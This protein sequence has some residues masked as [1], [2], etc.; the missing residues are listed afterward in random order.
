MKFHT[1]NAPSASFLYCLND[2][3]P[4][5]ATCLR[6]LAAHEVPAEVQSMKVV[7]PAA[8]PADTM[9]CPFFKEHSTLR[10]AWGF[11]TLLESL[12]VSAARQLAESL[13]ERW[14]RTAYY[15]LRKGE[16]ALTP[17]EQQDVADALREMGIDK[18]PVFDRYTE[19][20]DWG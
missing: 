20:T 16:Q 3:C 18:E 4:R 12:P 6:C 8:I 14:N 10:L 11:S 15:R 2:S 13:Q 5:C 7:N 9:L 19:V 17:T 1:T